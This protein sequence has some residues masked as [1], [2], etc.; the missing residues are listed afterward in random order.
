VNW[1]AADPGVG[2]PAGIRWLASQ[3]RA[4]A[5]KISAAR[6]T[7]QSAS[8]QVSA[9]EWTGSSRNAFDRVL[10]SIAADTN[11]LD[12][13]LDAQATALDTYAAQ[14]QELKDRQAALE[15]QRRNAS[16]DLESG[17]WKLMSSR[18]QNDS[19]VQSEQ[20]SGQTERTSSIRREQAG[21]Q[22][23]IDVANGTLRQVRAQ[24]DQLVGDRRRI[25]AAAA[26]ALQ[27]KDALGNLAAF[28]T[29]AIASASPRSL[30]AALSTLSKNDLALLL[31]EHPEL[32]D[33]LNRADPNDVR[34]WW[35][36]LASGADGTGF[37]PEQSLLI[38]A[39]PTVIGALNGV[40]P[41]A[42]VAANTI[43]AEAE[44][45]R[46]QAERNRLA[47]VI[48]TLGK[49]GIV[50]KKDQAR[51]E[52]LDRE[53]SYLKAAT[54][55][56]PSVQLYLFDPGHSRIIEMLGTPG[57]DTKHV[58]TFSP[59]TFANME[60]FY[61]GGTQQIAKALSDKGGAD[62]VAFVYKDGLFPGEDD[63]AGAR[64][65]L[66]G[67]L[68]ANDQAF[69]AKTGKVLAAF[70]TGLNSDPSLN[71]ARKTAIGHSWGLANVTSSEVAGAH[72]DQVISLSGAGMPSTW[73]PSPTTTY[74]DYSYPDLL[75][76]A[77]LA[78]IPTSHGAR[79]QVWDGNNPRA[80]PAFTHGA[81]YRGPDDPANGSA[82]R[83][84]GVL[85]SN[86]NLIAS[87]SDASADVLRD[88]SKRVFG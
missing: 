39:L 8:G 49:V 81:Y 23:G 2:E 83:D 30:L 82:P 87:S 85:L 16:S 13:G 68:Q 18:M 73:K 69:A 14:L 50:D 12:S 21:L 34:A 11:L 22:A 45:D 86:H 5:T 42:R 84:L 4:R 41:L 25:D 31:Q 20:L 53:I 3:R 36:S 35:E 44:L 70:G 29:S 71:A 10:N 77:Q 80:N 1:T 57:P 40:P 63:T 62:T 46:A 66:D 74:T 72:Y 67:V 51:L 76:L 15:L 60:G 61:S 28:T 48:A 79:G 88:L 47:V 75:Q 6:M 37:S 24:W 43:N 58:I 64:S 26:A 33:T 19:I 59:G 27:G 55:R 54:G 32:G 9:S 7:L 56:N 17:Q 52:Q 38:A 65:T 78:P